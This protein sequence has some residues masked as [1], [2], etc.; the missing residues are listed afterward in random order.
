MKLENLRDLFFQTLMDLYST[1][2]QSLQALPQMIAQVNDPRLKEALEIHAK[3]T[4]FQRDR[5]EE[6]CEELDLD[7]DDKFCIVAEAMIKELKSWMSGDVVPE[8]MDAGVIALIQKIEHY[9]IAA[10]GTARTYAQQ[11]GKTHVQG[12][13]EISLDEEKT[14]DLELTRIAESTVNLKAES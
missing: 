1:E 4:Q 7:P 8:V 5:L 3:K 14:H 10:Y 12:L 13:L 2:T 11:L 6:I 9:E